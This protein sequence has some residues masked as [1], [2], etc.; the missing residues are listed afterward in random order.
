MP[1]PPKLVVF[2]VCNT[3]YDANTTF[4]FARRVLADKPWLR[5]IDLALSHRAS[6]LFWAQA[7]LYRLGGIDVPRR[8]V[9]ASLRGIEQGD[10]RRAARAYVAEDLPARAIAETQGRLRQH[11]RAGDRVVLVSNSLDVVIEAIAEALG[12][13][14]RATRLAYRDGRCA[15]RLADDLTGRKLDVV[16]MIRGKHE[17]VPELVVYTD[18]L[19]DKALVE[20][21]NSAMVIIPPR[22]NR[23]SWRGVEAEYMVLER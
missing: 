17:P 23:A 13:E 18:N 14:W 22:G 11:Q 19:S 2:D 4:E 5:A 10:L 8:M 6:P 7:V 20:A 3:L 16:Q 9:I 1:S 21:A 15:G 12:V